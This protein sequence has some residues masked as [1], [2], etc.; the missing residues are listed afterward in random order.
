M[1]NRSGKE[2]VT[3]DVIIPFYG[4]VKYL[5][6]CIDSIKNQNLNN[7]RLNVVVVNDNPQIAIPDFKDSTN[8]K[9]SIINNE[10]NLGLT[11]NWNK[12]LNLRENK[13]FHLLHYDD[14]LEQNFSNKI[15]NDFFDKND[16]GMV[17][18]KWKNKYE[19]RLSTRYWRSKLKD[20]EI[21]ENL[22]VLEKGDSAIKGVMLASFVCSSVLLTKSA[23]DNSGIFREDLEYSTDEEYWARVAKNNNVLISNQ[24]LV[25]YRS[26]SGNYALQTWTQEKFA[27]LFVKTRLER[28]YQLSIVSESDLEREYEVIAL[29]FINISYKLSLNNENKW[30]KYY[31]EKAKEVH[32]NIVNNRHYNSISKIAQ[33]HSFLNIFEKLR[34][35]H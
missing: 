22:I 32:P 15:I 13:Y 9:V 1:D 8:I 26:H 4:E 31:L 3:C 29:T 21:A 35:A 12:C 11:K 30:A 17:I 2:L 27:D 6:E 7:L 16:V 33:R 23:I 5:I 18:C 19:N 10:Q 24:K 20:D 25:L 28:L 34:K 14:L